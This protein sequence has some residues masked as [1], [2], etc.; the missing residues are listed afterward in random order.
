MFKTL[1]YQYKTCSKLQFLQQAKASNND[2]LVSILDDIVYWQ[3]IGPTKAQYQVFQ[4]LDK[5][6]NINL[7]LYFQYMHSKVYIFDR[8]VSVVGSWNFDG[9]SA[10][11]SPET[12]LFCLDDHLRDQLEE[13]MIRDISNSIPFK[14]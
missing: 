10:N 6:P 9:F 7:W 4:D 14:R 11:K 1:D 5:H 8:L 3:R 12:M 2:L 13:S